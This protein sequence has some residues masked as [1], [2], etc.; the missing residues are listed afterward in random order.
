MPLDSSKL[1]TGPAN[2]YFDNVLLGYVGEGVVLHIETTA[3]PL[4]GAQAGETPLDKVVTGGQVYCE[5]PLRE[6]TLPNIAK[7]IAN[8]ILVTGAV[9]G[10]RVDITN[11]VG[12]SLRSIAKQ[13]KLA[14]IKAGVESTLPA[15]IYMF[16]YASAA[17]APVTIA[18]HPTN[19]RE[20]M[21]RFEVWPDATTNRWGYIGDV[22][23][24]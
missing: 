11:R 12:L 21:V 20:I 23:P 16:P 7:G 9:S 24:V 18:F 22:A 10:T 19:Q 3:T 5:V 6:I 4:R 1:E 17:D 15:D 8:A 13:L 14:K 2:V